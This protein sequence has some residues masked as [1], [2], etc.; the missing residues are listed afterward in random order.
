MAAETPQI[1][2]QFKRD[3]HLVLTGLAILVGIGGGLAA[4]GFQYLIRGGNVIAW[5]TAEYTLEYLAALPAW[6]KVLAPAV[7]GF[8]CAL[9]VYYF[10][11]EAKGH[12]VPEV[13]ESVALH[14]GRIR[15]RVVLAKLWASAISISSG[16][17][18]G[19]EGPIVQVGAAFGSSVGQ[20]LRLDAR[21]LRTLIGCGAAA[22]I[23]GT[24]NAPIAGTIFALEVILAEFGVAQFS[25][26]VISAV[27]STAICRSFLEEGYVFTV[28]QYHLQHPA[29]LLAYAVLGL[30]AAFVAVG[31]VRVLYGVEDLF[32]RLK[33]WAP[34]K[35]VVGGAIVG[36]IGL[37]FPHVLGPGNEAIELALT[38]ELVGTLLLV[39]VFAKTLAVAITVGSGGS[40]GVFAP[41]LFVGAMTG[42]AFGAAL[43]QIFPA[44]QPGAYAV[45]GMAALVGATT[46]APITAIV[47]IFELTGDYGL[48]LSLML[49]TMAA[50]VV[51]MSLQKQSIYTM[52]LARRG[53]ELRAGRDVNLL[54]GFR[55]EDVMRRDTETV[56]LSASAQDVVDAFIQHPGASLF[57]VDREQK[58]H[59]LIAANLS[60][61]IFA[62]AKDYGTL[63]TAQDLMSESGFPV[64][65]PGVSLSDV[66][67]DLS[68]YRGEI[69]V[70]ENGQLVGA[71]WPEDV[72]ALY[73]REVFKR[74]LHA[75]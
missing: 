28:P 22:G 70:V 34:S 36:A 45:V 25:P 14:G 35:A 40:G 21:R 6:Q 20:W 65:K 15:P 59:G 43:K 13:M 19:Q 37:L 42:G 24:F 61:E 16:G 73:N 46:H 10:S 8:L 72:I 31:F 4:L 11:R 27:V 60:R 54:R 69:P 18:V 71:V 39:L 32:D 48:I 30:V 68:A 26:I 1:P 55:I 66:M 38:G 44:V 57:V 51:S 47:I 17:S 41:S 5:G 52:K 29:E 63:I 58:F 62:N 53:I 2:A 23:G 9:I 56:P 50:T 33:L 3:E 74:E 7:G 64:V 49:T 67:R 75:T 12:G